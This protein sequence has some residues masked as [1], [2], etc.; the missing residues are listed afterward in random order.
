MALL[1]ASKP[2]TAPCGC[3]TTCRGSD[4]IA[5]DLHC[6]LE[7]AMYG[8]GLAPAPRVGP[9]GWYVLGL[10]TGLA[11]WWF[12]GWLERVLS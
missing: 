7:R 9:E 3:V 11:L 4:K 5:A 12:A 1:L 6:Q 8:D 10:T 2:E